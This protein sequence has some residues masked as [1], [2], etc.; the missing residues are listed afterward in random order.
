MFVSTKRTVVELVAVE[1]VAPVEV[2]YLVLYPPLQSLQPLELGILRRQ[3]FE[4]LSHKRTQR[5]A[6]LRGADSRAPIHLVRHCDSDVLHVQRLAQKHGCCAT[7][8]QDSPTGTPPSCCRA[9]RP[10]PPRAR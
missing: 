7:R 9:R 6:L 10:G 5:P 4:E 3:S 8:P 1:T 2:P